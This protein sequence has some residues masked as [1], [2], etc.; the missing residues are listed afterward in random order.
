MDAP[1]HTTKNTHTHTHTGT[2]TLPVLRVRLL[3]VPRVAEL[4]SLAA[5]AYAHPR[6]TRNQSANRPLGQRP[7]HLNLCERGRVCVCV[8]A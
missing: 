6:Q 8:C 1:T 5:P 3:R 4:W 2:H 7:L